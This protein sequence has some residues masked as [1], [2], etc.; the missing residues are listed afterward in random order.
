[1]NAISVI[2]PTRERTVKLHRAIGSYLDCCESLDIWLYVH[3]DDQET[4][5]Y[6]I[7][8][9]AGNA[10]VKWIVGRPFYKGILGPMHTA[11]KDMARG[12]FIWMGNDDVVMG[13]KVY[14]DKLNTHTVYQPEIHKLNTSVYVADENCPF[15]IFHRSGLD[16]FADPVDIST[17][18]FLRKKGW[19]TQ[20]LRGVTVW[21]DRDEA[22]CK[23]IA[24]ML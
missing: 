12:E 17:L 1:M 15:F 9:W 2:I 10:R 19:S 14:P 8:T 24:K 20:Y 23:K 13:G 5:D 11:L 21:H 18:S 3:E 4:Q 16:R 22:D 6:V 7:K